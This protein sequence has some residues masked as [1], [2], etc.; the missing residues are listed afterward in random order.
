VEE[1]EEE[2]LSTRHTL[3]GVDEW[4]FLKKLS[5]DWKLLFVCHFA[6]F[7]LSFTWA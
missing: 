3:S 5:P 1:A 4:K 2:E 6:A 7:T